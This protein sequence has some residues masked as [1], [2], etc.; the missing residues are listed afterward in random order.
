MKKAVITGMGCVSGLGADVASTWASLLAGRS[1]IIQKTIAV[2][3]LDEYQFEGPVAPCSPDALTK[4]VGKF[5]EKQIASVDLFSNFGASATLEALSDAGLVDDAERLERAAII[6]GSATGGNITMEAGYE[7]VFLNRLPNVHPMTIPRFMNSANVSYL[8]MIFGVRGH[9]LA[10]SS[11]C[12]TSAH[13]IGE[14]MHLIRAGRASIV[15]TGGSDASLTYGSLRSWVALQAM[16]TDTCRPFSMGRNGMV[17]GEGA[18]TLI[19][20]EEEHARRRGAKIYAEVAGTGSTADASHIT[21]PD[22]A[23]AAAAIRAAHEDAGITDD[24]AILYSAHGT[25]TKLNDRSES[26]ALRLA[27]PNSFANHRVIATKSAHGHMLGATGAMEF[28]IAIQ[29]LR[30][31]TAPHILNYVGHDPDC[32][33]PLVLEPEEISSEIAVSASFAFGGLNSVLLARKY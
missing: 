12:A 28:L 10:V 5:T 25:G 17:I 23:N 18:A 20:E 8:S 13:A 31:N 4:L 16:A 22:P 14:A 7:R 3:G 1:A 11:A 15:I 29:A 19:L 6:Y 21:K 24:G 30:E 9:C 27:Y 32:D 26:A 33:L 2:K